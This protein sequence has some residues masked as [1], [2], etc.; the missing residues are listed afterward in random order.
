MPITTVCGCGKRITVPDDLAGKSG[1]CGRC[2][3][4]QSIP[5]PIKTV[6]P[7][8]TLTVACHLC[9]KVF[10]VATAV[11]GRK[12]RCPGC[13][14]LV[15]VPTFVPT[16]ADA[17]PL[18]VI[19][20]EDG[21]PVK[22]MS[23]RP[24]QPI[25][26]RFLLFVAAVVVITVVVLLAMRLSDASRDASLLPIAVY[27]LVILIYTAPITIPVILAR[28]GHLSMSRW[29]VA[30]AFCFA[31]GMLCLG[32]FYLAWSSRVGHPFLDSTA[33]SIASI[34]AI[35]MPFSFIGVLGCLLAAVVH[36]RVET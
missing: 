24:G 11:A 33:N 14:E 5:V 12:F 16:P 31:T 7:S 35:P 18:M 8:G 3:A 13:F 26:I 20:A 28:R 15:D 1:K 34:S 25:A 9:S 10:N 19:D 32:I 30:A 17:I 2:G 6:S 4:R 23:R 29:L 27:S 36:K 22:L 21:R